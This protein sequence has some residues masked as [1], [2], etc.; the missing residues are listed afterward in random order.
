VIVL[1]DKFKKKKVGIA[2]KYYC[3][4]DNLEY[5]YI[6]I[7]HKLMKT[8]TNM[9]IA[10]TKEKLEEHY[11]IIDTDDKDIELLEALYG[12]LSPAK[13]KSKG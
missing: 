7:D 9:L 6:N 1:L 3:P 11:I 10:H 13:E 12:R 2:K 4:Q 5:Y 8:Y